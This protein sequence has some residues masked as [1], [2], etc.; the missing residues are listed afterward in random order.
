MIR[1][2]IQAIYTKQAKVLFTINDHVA[3]KEIVITKVPS[4]VF[5]WVLTITPR[6]TLRNFKVEISPTL[7][8]Q[9]LFAYKTFIF[10]YN[11]KQHSKLK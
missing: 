5:A 4:I 7:H 6:P 3:S 10:L 11:S 2:C 9:N 1:I 8:S